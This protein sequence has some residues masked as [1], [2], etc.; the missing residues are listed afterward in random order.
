MGTNVETAETVMRRDTFKDQNEEEQEEAEDEAPPKV[1]TNLSEWNCDHIRIWLNSVSNMFNIEKMPS[2]QKF[3][4]T[5]KEL[6]QLSRRQFQRITGDSYMAS[7]LSRHLAFLQGKPDEM[8]EEEDNVDDETGSDVE[9]K[10]T[11]SQSKTSRSY[12]PN[13]VGKNHFINSSLLLLI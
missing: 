1:P 5:G 3:P 11:S 7:I 4:R 6:S 8:S 2:V 12:P 10:L 9:E 13:I